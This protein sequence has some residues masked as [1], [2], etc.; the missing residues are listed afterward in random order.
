METVRKI[1]ERRRQ[2][3][4]AVR[5]LESIPA[6][7][8]ESESLRIV[9][10]ED[11][12]MIFNSPQ[13]QQEWND[14]QAALKQACPIEDG[15]TDGVNPGDR[16]AVWYLIKGF[17]PSSVLEIGTN[18]GAS[19]T[20]IASALQSLARQDA[21]IIPRL[22]TLDVQDVNG[23]SGFWKQRGLD[24]SPRDRIESIG[25]GDFVSF[26]TENSLRYFDRCKDEFD[27]IF[28]DGDHS[29]AAVYQEIPRALSVL[30]KDGI[31]LL[32]DYFPRNR[33]IWSNGSLV[34]GPYTGA[35]RLI[36]EGVP[37]KVIP[38]GELPWPTK[39]GSSYT[40]LA[41]VTREPANLRNSESR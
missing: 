35:A 32:H 25:C 34:A 21:S 22:V 17:R 30:K 20:H 41:L 8:G 15:K 7:T 2:I 23:V 5:S 33:P 26:V 29:A 40:S 9:S 18:V 10:D 28:L 19:T 39:L 31:I 6:L 36:S 37:I 16:R 12:A 11:L 13:I 4:S 27:F 3:S 24:A 1:F 14:S 38:L